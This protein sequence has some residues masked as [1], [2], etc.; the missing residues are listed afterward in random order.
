MDSKIENEK[1]RNENKDLKIENEKLKNENKDLKIENEKLK[2]ENKDLKI[3]NN[4]LK[5]ENKD[6]KIENNKLKNENQTVKKE[7]Q[8]LKNRRNEFIAIKNEEVNRLNEKIKRLNDKIKKLNEKIK[9]LND[10]KT[11]YKDDLFSKTYN[12]IVTSNSNNNTL[13]CGDKFI[14]INFVSVDQNIN[15]SIICKNKTKFHDIE[16]KLYTKYPKYAENDNYFMFNGSKVN[17]WKTLE[18]NDI[19]G[20][21]VILNKVDNK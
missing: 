2:N 4:K 11:K 10:E 20:Y 12:N 3:E 13:S 8:I 6:L 17:R 16:D 21:T 1:L 5:N 9:N 15:H 14:A 7:I 18:E 19:N